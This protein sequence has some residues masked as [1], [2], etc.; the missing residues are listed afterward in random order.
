MLQEICC[1]ALAYKRKEETI[2]KTLTRIHYTIF[3]GEAQEIESVASAVEQFIL[4]LD[5]IDDIQ[6]NDNEDAPWSRIDSSQSLNV[7]LWF[8][9]VSMQ[10]ILR[11]GLPNVSTAMSHLYGNFITSI[12]G[13]DLDLNNSY[14]TEE[15]YLE[16]CK[17]KSG[18]LVVMC[19][20]MGTA[21]A[22]N[23]YHE[24]V[25]EYSSYVGIAAQI[26]NDINDLIH[27]DKK[28]DL[29]LKKKTL[30]ILFL[31]QQNDEKSELLRKYFANQ[32]DYTELI[33]CKEEVSQI[34]ID[35]GALVYANAVKEM[36]KEKARTVMKSLPIH[37]DKVNWL[38]QSILE[39]L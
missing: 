7:A 2:F 26:S 19:C 32:V 22:T 28:S 4:A 25:E 10:E 36:Y 39:N 21:L 38:T 33:K 8:L 14:D 35:S 37:E 20:L 31:L 17:K 18:A 6:D 16:M 23:E 34:L 13:Q 27:F 15:E 9:S 12:E 30:P 5:I 11:T 3:E 29:R 24:I 1:E